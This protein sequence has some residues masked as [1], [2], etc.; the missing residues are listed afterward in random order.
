MD[1]PVLVEVTRGGIVESAHRGAVAV[2]DAAG[3]PLLAL[4]DID[5]PVFPRSAVKALQA[6]P[7]IESGAAERFGLT[8]AG[9]ALACA[10][11][12]GEPEHAETAA[13]ML[14]AAGRDSQCLE[15]GA[16][17]PM[18]DAAARALAAS[19]RQPSA[20]HNNCSGKHAGFICLAL[21]E[22]HDPRGYIGPD[23]P[24]MRRVT[25]ALGEMTGFDLARTARGIDGCSIPTYAVPLRNLAHAFARFG[26][27]AGLAPDRARAAARIRAAVAASPFHVAGS[28]RFDTLAMTALGARAFVKTGAEG[29]YCAALPEAGLGIALKIEDGASRAAEIVMA[30]LI[31]RFLP[32]AAQE[33]AAIAALADKP[34]TNWNGVEFGRLRPAPALAG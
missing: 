7:L 11:H 25:A 5:R 21:H 32:L 15:C 20:L 2:L 24:A 23:H 13:A 18:G 3:R 19:G 17:W 31:A 34:L 22:G 16:H 27:G 33:A 4:G 8:D 14:A 12:S 26:T 28:G 29:V 1:A 6:L 30:A 10:S 9:I